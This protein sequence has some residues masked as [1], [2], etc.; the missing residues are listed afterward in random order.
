MSAKAALRRECLARRKAMSHAEV[1]AASEAIA[2]RVL[3]LP[4]YLSAPAIY[5]YIAHQNEV[6][7]RAI[8]IDAL[9][10]GKTVYAPRVVGDTLAW[11]ELT[12]LEDL[13]PGAYGILEPPV[14]VHHPPVPTAADLCLVP[15]VCFREDGHRLGRGGGH[16]DRFLQGFPGVSVGLA[17]GWQIRE[18]L[19]VERHDVAVGLVVTE[20]GLVRR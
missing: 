16:Y 13:I 4:E 9:L 14:G 17:Y 2:A 12:A 6:D 15:G 3:A 7:T 8:L 11:G 20:L 5:G 10:R 19:A 1:A 18:D